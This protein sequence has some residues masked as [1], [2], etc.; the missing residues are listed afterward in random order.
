LLEKIF[1]MGQGKQGVGRKWLT[2][3]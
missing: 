3:N 1:E 2:R